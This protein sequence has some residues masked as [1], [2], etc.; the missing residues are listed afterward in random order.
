MYIFGG[1]LIITIGVLCLDLGFIVNPHGGGGVFPAW[2]AWTLIMLGAIMF[3]LS[4]WRLYIRR[5]I[6][7][8]PPLPT[9]TDE[10]VERSIEDMDDFYRREYGEEPEKPKKD[11]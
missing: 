1:I 7:K 2:A 8:P 3:A 5:G 4:L 9:Y 6:P 10:E 11:D